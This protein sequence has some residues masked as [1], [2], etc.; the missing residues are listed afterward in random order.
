MAS[1]VVRSASK[2]GLVLLSSQVKTASDGFVTI[3][4][5]FLAPE[6][7]I[8]QEF[9]LDAKWPMPTL[10]TSTP[11]LQGGPY[12]LDKTIQKLNGLTIIQAT[13]VS[14]VA[15]IRISESKNTEFCTFSGYAESSAGVSGTLSFDYYT[16]AVTYEFALIYPSSAEIAPV[17]ELGRQFNIKKTGTS[18][19]V[20][21]KQVEIVTQNETKVGPVARR[22]VTARRTFEQDNVP[23]VVVSPFYGAT[24][25]GTPIWNPWSF[26]GIN[27]RVL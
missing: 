26:S 15:P 9:D 21:T 12:L 6:S 3:N 5:E 17:G 8:K 16:T 4:A 7:G 18:S 13:F 14:A 10:P 19:L 2:K 25:N 22:S 11:N 23:E 27:S 24:I 1:T 20:T